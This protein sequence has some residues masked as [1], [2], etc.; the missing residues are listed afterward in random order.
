[1]HTFLSGAALIKE[2]RGGTK[3]LVGASLLFLLACGG[4]G[5]STAGPATNPPVNPPVT[6]VQPQLVAGASSSLALKS[7]GTAWAW[8]YN[9]FGEL[10]DGTG[11]Q[12]RQPVQVKGLSDIQGISMGGSHALALKK[13]GTLWGWGNNKYG[14]V[15]A[16]G[17]GP[18]AP[19]QVAA[20]SDVT[21]F[22]AYDFHSLAARK[23]GSA[24]IWGK[25]LF[26][27]AA[28]EMAVFTP[29]LAAPSPGFLD[30]ALGFA[31]N[32]VIHFAW[33]ANGSVAVWGLNNDGLLGTGSSMPDR[34]AT[35]VVMGTLGNVKGMAVNGHALAVKADGTVW[36]WG[37]NLEGETGQ[38]PS[39]YVYTPTQ[40]PGLG[41]AI[42]VAAGS[43]YSCALDS[44]GKVWTWG[45]N[46]YGQLGDGT[47]KSHLVPTLVAGLEG[48]AAI[49]AGDTHTLALKRDGT[50]WA[51]GNDA[52]GQLGQGNATGT[53]S[54]VPIQVKGLTLR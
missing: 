36:A 52:S 35:P 33:F 29:K 19:A 28:D 16:G 4:G 46:N 41:K 22:A 37:N 10:G 15:G 23:D 45:L 1:M 7:D 43:H 20:L 24:W 32:N 18:V 17:L 14:E 2:R 50:V 31:G 42:A 13:D 48:V 38:A 40:V 39:R 34:Q 44:D 12:Q 49:A 26:A 8:G 9:A 27:L 30:H 51:W 6:T 11:I 5:G 47:T 25:D 21:A 3:A 53:M 54:Q